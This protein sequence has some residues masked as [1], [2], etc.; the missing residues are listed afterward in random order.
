MVESKPGVQFDVNMIQEE[1]KC[2]SATQS[3]SKTRKEG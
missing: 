3:P 1:G 2:E